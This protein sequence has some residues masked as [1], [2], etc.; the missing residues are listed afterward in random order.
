MEQQGNTCK[1]GTSH[2]AVMQLFRVRFYHT[3]TIIGKVNNI[4]MDTVLC[5]LSLFLSL[6]LGKTFDEIKEVDVIYL[7]FQTAFDKGPT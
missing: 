6:S 7:D 4:S 2:S 1:F 3:W 5:P